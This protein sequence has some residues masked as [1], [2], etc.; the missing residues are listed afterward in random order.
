MP[1]RGRGRGLYYN[2]ELRRG[3]R[4][5]EALRAQQVVYIIVSTL[6][7]LTIIQYRMILNYLRDEYQD[8]RCKPATVYHL[9]SKH[10]HNLKRS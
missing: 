3:G 9:L 5:D 1:S 10:Q 2:K 8:Y 7:C 4:G 6:L